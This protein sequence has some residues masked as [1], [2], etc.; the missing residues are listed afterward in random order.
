MKS[1]KI[2]LGKGLS[3]LLPV[4]ITR[5]E[6]LR[7]IDI[8][9]VSVGAQPRRFFEE[10]SI[11]ELAASIREKGILQP[12]LVVRE[13][14]GYRLIAG[15]RRLRAAKLAGLKS[16][17][18]V[19]RDDAGSGESFEIALIENIQR[20]DLTPVE[21]ALAYK[22]LREEFSLNQSEIAKRV[23]KERSSIANSMR[24]LNLPARVIEMLGN[25]E[26]SEGAAR[27]LIAVGD[28]K[29]IVELAERISGSD[30]SVRD[31][32]RLASG[33]NEGRAKK[34]ERSGQMDEYFRSIRNTLQKELDTNVKVSGRGN[35]GSITIEFKSLNHLK[36]IVELLTGA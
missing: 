11:L 4:S 33:F 10:S 23:G 17:P 14:N 20:R 28:E 25:G 34:R 13:D 2:V 24:L 31:V 9:S 19:V 6:G 32:E 16:I 1:K 30:M 5:G 12:L 18:A 26:L 35:R 36:R 21:E 27:A 22:R 8:E 7:Q 29:K 15:E 3:A